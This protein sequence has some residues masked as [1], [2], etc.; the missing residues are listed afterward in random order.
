ME[1]RA[2]YVAVGAF[3]LAML[4]AI[5]V[6]VA[7]LGATSFNRDFAHYDIYF[8]GSVTGLAQ[9]SAVLYNGIQVGRVVE[10]RLSAK[11]PGQV[12]TTIEIDPTIQIKS[13]ATAS[14]EVQGLTGT[15]VINISGGSQ[16]APPLQRREGERYPV[17]ASRQ[18]GLQQFVASA[19]EALSRLI[20]VADRLSQIFDDKNRAA[21]ADT[22]QNVRQLT[23]VAAG[24]SAD[25]DTALA[26]AAVA[27][28]D[29]RGTAAELRE[30]FGPGD[31]RNMFV[32]MSD[33]AKKLDVLADHLDSLVQENRPP[34][35]DFTQNGL[36]QLSQ[37][38]VDARAL[39]GSLN[40]IADDLQ[41]DPPR[42]LF[43][44]D[45]REGY[46]PR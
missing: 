37:L 20:E 17:I 12:R 33:T 16:D 21:L 24:R 41:R 5:V 3:V 1:T 35:H 30:L 38:M 31:A 8:Q 43:G 27:A 14:L 42:F 45:R 7:W 26:D 6:A 11:N 9:G 22:L 44:A 23:A 4:V 19:P 2:N 25:I 40:R 18:S 36:N 34:L 10:I 15:A 39:V 32:T 29:L 28:H 13:D 46:Q